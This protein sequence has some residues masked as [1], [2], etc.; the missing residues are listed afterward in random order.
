YTLVDHEGNGKALKLNGTSQFLTVTKKDGSSLLT[1]MDEVEVSFQM[2]PST[3]ATNWGFF[4]AP[5]TNEQKYQQ[6]HYIGVVNISGTVNAERYNN[7]GA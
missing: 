3:S 6:E 7:S 4:A 2:K 5:N 1:G